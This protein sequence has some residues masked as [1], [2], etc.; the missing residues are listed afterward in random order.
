MD[1]T[2]AYDPT[3]PVDLEGSTNANVLHE[4]TFGTHMEYPDGSVPMVAKNNSGRMSPVRGRTMK[5]YDQQLTELKKENFSL[6]LRIYFLEERMQQKFGDSDVFKTNIELKVELE[7]V[8]NEY[9]DKQELLKKASNAMEAMSKQHEVELNGIRDQ[10]EKEHQKNTKQLLDE[11]NQKHQ[12]K[13]F[14]HAFRNINDSHIQHFSRIVTVYFSDVQ[15]A[16]D[17]TKKLEDKEGELKALQKEYQDMKLGKS[18]ALEQKHEELNYLEEK[19]LSTQAYLQQQETELEYT[20]YCKLT[21][22]KDLAEKFIDFMESFWNTSLEEEEKVLRSFDSDTFNLHSNINSYSCNGTYSSIS[23]KNDYNCYD[24]YP[25]KLM[26][27]LGKKEGELE[28]FKDLLT[29]AE[30]ALIQS[31][32]AVD[33]LF[34]DAQKQVEGKDQL[35]KN[36]TES[37]QDKDRQIQYCMEIFRPTKV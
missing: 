5:E 29:K 34:E 13:T 4:V 12:E 9:S 20:F 15:D 24:M 10:I 35:V 27:T 2:C 25:Q 17:F 26:R 37:L 23:F 1:S 31:E 18:K 21:F 36:L 19:E 33:T 6:K 7:S 30:N 28:S 3:L 14:K 32:D 8:K 16:E 11:I 22:F